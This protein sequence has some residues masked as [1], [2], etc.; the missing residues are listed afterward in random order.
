[1]NVIPLKSWFTSLCRHELFIK[2][3]QNGTCFKKW[4]T[5]PYKR[6]F[7]LPLLILVT[8]HSAFTYIFFPF[9]FL[10]MAHLFNDHS[11]QLPPPSFFFFAEAKHASAR[12]LIPFSVYV[13]LLVP[14][15]SSLSIRDLSAPQFI[16]S[17][18]TRTTKQNA[19]ES[20][21]RNK[22]KEIKHSSMETSCR[23]VWY[24]TSRDRW[25]LGLPWAERS[26]DRGTMW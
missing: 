14:C 23:W 26:R 1:M 11:W 10:V 7:F 9:P 19:L 15:Q 2:L 17:W 22:T 16:F 5:R 21:R 3:Y 25:K 12:P 24:Y 20:F 18:H 6:Y 13:C 4:R 8:F